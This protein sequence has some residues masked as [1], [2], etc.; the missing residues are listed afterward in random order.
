MDPQERAAIFARL[1]PRHRAHAYRMLGSLSEAEDAVQEAYIRWHQ[2]E[3]AEVRSPEAW[4]LTVLTRLCIDQLRL[5]KTRRETYVGAWLPEPLL[6]EA[7]AGGTDLVE[8]AS[9]LSMALLMVLERLSP[10]ERAAFLLHDVFEHD[11]AEVAAAIGKSEVACRQILHR[12]RTRVQADRPRF[13]VAPAER[14]R[15]LQRFLAATRDGD[16]AGLKALFAADITVW[17]DG[18]G[19][20]KAALNP[21][22]GADKAARLFLGITPKQPPGARVE[23]RQING[24]PGLVGYVDG[25]P[26]FSL[27][28]EVADGVITAIHAVSNP[29]KLHHLR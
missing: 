7:D 29:D 4:L 14:T 16:T 17:S 2:A 28:V 10:V 1:R 27:T 23:I 9:N 12:A 21:I 8:F 19:K 20:A 6:T 5:A 25:V 22:H 24:A 11:H 3:A 15:L 18:G 13:Q 26:Y